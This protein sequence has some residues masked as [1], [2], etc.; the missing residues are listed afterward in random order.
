MHGGGFM[1]DNCIIIKF[2]GEV[3]RIL[4]QEIVF[5]EQNLRKVLFHLNSEVCGTYG[6]IEN[7]MQNLPE[8]FYKCNKSYVINLNKVIKMGNQVI[9]FSD[10]N[11]IRIGRQ[12]FHGAKKAFLEFALQS[13]L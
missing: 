13:E 7:Y 5:V 6:K 10:G 9:Y 4:P 2:K 8:E 11:D 1:K 3:R 12:S